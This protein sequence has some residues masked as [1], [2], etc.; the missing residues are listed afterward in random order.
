MFVEAPVAQGDYQEHSLKRND[1]NMDEAV[2]LGIM[3]KEIRVAKRENRPFDLEAAASGF[4]TDFG[5]SQE[6]KK[7]KR[8]ASLFWS[9]KIA[10]GRALR[11]N[12]FDFLRNS[13][14][15]FERR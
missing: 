4:S 3:E 13:E 6:F 14:E 1:A 7:T 2:A 8:S 15:T 10:E 12:V 11:A 5:N 9:A